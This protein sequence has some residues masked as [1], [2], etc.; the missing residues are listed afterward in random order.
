MSFNVTNSI[1]SAI[2]S[3]TFGLQKASDGISQAS[4]SIAQ[5]TA[6]LKDTNTLLAETATQ[7]LG[8]TGSLMSGTGGGDSFTSDILSLSNH[9]YYAQASSKVIG[10][11]KE[12][13]GKIIDELA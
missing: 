7:Q 9:L 4:I 8:I 1:N 12:V 11:A 5:K 6:A 3:G 10:S 13:V 2:V